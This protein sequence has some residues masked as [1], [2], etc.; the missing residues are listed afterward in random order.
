VFCY[1]NSTCVVPLDSRIFN[2]KKKTR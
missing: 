1:H 2:S